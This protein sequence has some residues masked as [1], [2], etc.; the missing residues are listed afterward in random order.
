MP[1]FDNL[2]LGARP[3][4]PTDLFK[5]EALGETSRNNGGGAGATVGTVSDQ[6]T[7]PG[8][9]L[10]TIALLGLGIWWIIKG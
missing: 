2:K 5:S 9:P 4:S 8:S 6:I 1:T 7:P 3:I 10:L